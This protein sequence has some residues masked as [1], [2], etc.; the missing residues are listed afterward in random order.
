MSQIFGGSSQKSTSNSVS[1]SSNQAY[2]YLNGALSGTVSNGTG[3]GDQLASM[4]GLNGST[5]QSD[6]F[7]KWK[8][9]TGYQ[10]GLNQGVQSITGN[11]ATQGLLNSGSTAKALDTYGQNYANTQYQNY[12][13]PLQNLLSS[14]LQ[15]AGVISSAGNVSNSTSNSNSSGNSNNG[16]VGGFIGSLLAK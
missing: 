15:G 12:L 4:L 3:A 16:G 9:S 10:F 13:N 8:D 2:P 1:S 7:N 5:G 14:G 11:A 6:A